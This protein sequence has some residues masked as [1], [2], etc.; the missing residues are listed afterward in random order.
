[1]ERDRTGEFPAENLKKMGK[2]GYM[3]KM[4]PTQYNGEGID[5]AIYVLALSEM[6]YSCASTAV[7]MAVPN[8]P[9]CESTNWFWTEEQKGKYVKILDNVQSLH[10]SI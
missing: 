7:V 1:M 4:I 9:V 3:G 6:A 8:Y 10:I 2:L 5:T